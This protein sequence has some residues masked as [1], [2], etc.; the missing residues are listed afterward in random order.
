MLFPDQIGHEKY[1]ESTEGQDFHELFAEKDLE[2][3]SW[4]HT[5]PAKIGCKLTLSRKL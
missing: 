5:H 1:F 4:I 2:I 3:K